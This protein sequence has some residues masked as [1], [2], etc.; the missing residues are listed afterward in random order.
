VAR[1]L[2]D[3]PEVNAVAQ[4]V[5]DGPDSFPAPYLAGELGEA[6]EVNALV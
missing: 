3:G 2:S 1:T 4:G 5:L 6:A